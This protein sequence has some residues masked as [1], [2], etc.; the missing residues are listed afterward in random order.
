MYANISLMRLC[1]LLPRFYHTPIS[2]SNRKGGF[3]ITMQSNISNFLIKK[4]APSTP[5]S[6]ELNKPPNSEPPQKSND[7]VH[8]NTARNTIYSFVVI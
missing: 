5:Q 8:A 6:G 4:P 3:A 1:T 2:L 7:Q